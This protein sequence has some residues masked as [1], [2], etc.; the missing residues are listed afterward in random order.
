MYID[1]WWGD[2]IGGS[3]DALSLL[4]YLEQAEETELSLGDV[5]RELGFE[6]LLRD[7]DLKSGGAIGFAS[8]SEDGA[9]RQDIQIA[10]S[11][12]IDLAAIVLESQRSGSVDLQDLDPDRPSR[13]L[14]IRLT[15]A[16]RQLLRSEL[17]QFAAAPADYELAD[18]IDEADLTQLVAQVQEIAEQL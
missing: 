17:L 10:C 13:K 9:F 8:R 18:Y 15:E 1:K 7:G 11:A 5:L 14:Q 16:D 12:F 4:D 3:D 2:Y 6:E